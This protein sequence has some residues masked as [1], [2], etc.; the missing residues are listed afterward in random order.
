MVEKLAVGL[1]ITQ[2]PPNV[3]LLAIPQLASY[4]SSVA[5]TDLDF[6]YIMLIS[7]SALTS[8]DFLCLLLPNR[9]VLGLHNSRPSIQTSPMQRR[10]L[11]RSQRVVSGSIC[12]A[13]LTTPMLLPL[14]LQRLA[15]INVRLL[16]LL[17]LIMVVSVFVPTLSTRQ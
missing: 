5:R 1:A 14:L 6:T 11:A 17:V 10:R 12:T 3:T 9:S 16:A 7:S 13:L 2:P 15:F 4:R 8:S